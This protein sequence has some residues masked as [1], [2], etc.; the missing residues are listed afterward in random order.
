MRTRKS[1]PT[2]TERQRRRQIIDL[3]ASH[4][5]R[6][7]EAVA[8]SSPRPRIVGQKNFQNPAKPDL[9]CPPR[10]RS[11]CPPVNAGRARRKDAS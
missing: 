6:M 10:C 1:A 9:M 2:L 7:P 8:V 5:A 4:V 11:V 3:L